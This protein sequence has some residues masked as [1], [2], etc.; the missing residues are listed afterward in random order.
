MTSRNEPT[1]SP[2]N[3]ASALTEYEH[4]LYEESRSGRLSRRAFL[5]RAAAMGLAAPTIGAIL[6][7]CGTSTH[8]GA[9][10]A[11]SSPP[12]SR[13]PKGGGTGLI[14]TVT[15]TGVPDPVTM[16]DEG[17]I[18]AV[19]PCGEYLLVTDSTSTLRPALA[20]SWKAISPTEFLF[21]LRR[22]VTFHNGQPFTADDVVYTFD[23][24]TNPKGESAALAAFKGILTPGNIEKVDSHT[25]RFHLDSP[26]VDFPY[27]VSQFTYNSIILPNHYQ[28]GTY[29]KGGYGTGPFYVTRYTPGV[30]TT[31]R[32]NTSY[33][34]KGLPYLDGIELTFFGTGQ[35]AALSMA[36]GDQDYLPGVSYGTAQ[37][38][39]H[40]PD[41]HI[42]NSPSSSFRTLQMRTDIAPFDDPNLRLAVASCLQRP[43][44]VKALLG[45]YG[46]VGNDDYFA[47]VFPLSKLAISSVPQRHQDYSLARKYLA[48]AGKPRGFTV[49][50]TTEQ[51]AEIPDYAAIVK[52]QCA[53]VGIDINLDVE[54]QAEYYGS[55]SNQPWLSV[56]F[57]I[58]DWGSRGVPSQV[59]GDA[60]I[61][62]AV[63][64]SAHWCD[65]T[66]TTLFHELNATL[67]E[68]RRLQI[69]ARMAAIQHN[70]CPD[71]IAYWLN[72]TQAVRKG[73]QVGFAP[74][75]QISVATMSVRT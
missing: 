48:K 47:P 44:L 16:A 49:T 25:V 7:A 24:L 62:G 70:A 4:H 30:S 37:E 8:P 40:K 61:C 60:F 5:C 20:T 69:A 45:G 59:I 57:G 64:N 74:A 13:R 2:S 14:A 75:G 18:I 3:L 21:E 1:S 65:P 9:S 34:A 35:A 46:Q 42:L 36:G 67:D 63:W 55:G 53:P 22:G 43:D 11:S 38:L 29:M 23:L 51:Y 31:Y 58:T 41:I 19:Q 50:L 33:W 52:Q 66:F 56:P 17:S 15:P 72:N 12:T 6:S 71:V 27:L 68:Q 54:I 10:P 32:A 26:F 73:V 28:I 39:F